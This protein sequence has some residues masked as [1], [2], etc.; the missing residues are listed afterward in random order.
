M[1]V[2]LN[3]TVFHGGDTLNMFIAMSNHSSRSPIVD[4]WL[5]LRIMSGYY[6]FQYD[7]S[8]VPP[9]L[10]LN[11]VPTPMITFPFF[12]GTEIPPINIWSITFPSMEL[13]EPLDCAFYFALLSAGNSELLSN[14]SEFNF[15]IDQ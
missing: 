13:Y 5:I 4:A 10:N 7:T 6:F 3:A 12:E 8:T 9:T 1:E 11:P 15:E 2:T 14:V